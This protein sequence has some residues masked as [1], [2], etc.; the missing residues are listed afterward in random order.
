MHGSMG[1][2]LVLSTVLKGLLVQ[3]V[4]FERQGISRLLSSLK[5][6]THDAMDATSVY[7]GKLGRDILNMISRI[8]HA[9]HRTTEDVDEMGT[10]TSQGSPI[11]SIHLFLVPTD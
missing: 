9:V 2:P 8:Q 4:A 5:R 10:G 3:P 6:M 11:K 7:P 1:R